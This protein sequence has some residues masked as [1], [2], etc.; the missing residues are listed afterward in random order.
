MASYYLLADPQTT[1]LMFNGGNEPASSWSRHWSPA[2]AYDV[3]WPKG[4]W[5]LVDTGS[6]PENPAL[7]Y[8]VLQR[9]YDNALVLYKP[10]SYANG[11]TGTTAGST[12][13][14][15]KSTSRTTARKTTGTTATKA[16]TKAPTGGI[17]NVV[18]TT[19]TA[20]RT[21]WPSSPT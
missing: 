13:T 6:D 10:L 14:T 11:V 1:F 16:A 19:S 17:G 9:R 12:V 7:T 15:A 20:P 5:S 18:A 3:G 4:G 2:A 21:G 8:Q